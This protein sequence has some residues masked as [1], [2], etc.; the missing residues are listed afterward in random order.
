MNIIAKVILTKLLGWKVNGT[1]PDIKKSIVIFAPH[2]S[3]YDGLYG[4]LFMMTTGSNYKFLSKKEFFKFPYK[5]FFKLYGSIPVYENSKYINDIVNILDQNDSLHLVMSP[6]GQLAKTDRWKK[7]F[8]YMAINAKVPIVVT[9]LDYTKKEVG[10]KGIIESTTN[11]KTTME[12]I[13][14]YYKDVAAKYPE[15]FSLDKRF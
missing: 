12:L 4:K 3:Y 5:Y 14:N 1:F 11:F 8:Y 6:E 9:Y 2:T 10:V 7:G 13:N 15:K